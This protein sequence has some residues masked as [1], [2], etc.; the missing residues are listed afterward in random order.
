MSLP[1]LLTALCASLFA[2]APMMIEMM[3]T[4]SGTAP[5]ISPSSRAAPTRAPQL[6]NAVGMPA[7]PTWP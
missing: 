1:Q 6:A 4:M 5:T 3:P 7:I 2:L